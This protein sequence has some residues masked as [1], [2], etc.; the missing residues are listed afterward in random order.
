MSIDSDLRDPEVRETSAAPTTVEGIGR[1]P[2]PIHPP[3]WL[4]PVSIVLMVVVAAIIGVYVLRS[5]DE[6]TT[7]T[8]TASEP[9]IGPEEQ[10]FIDSRV[11]PLGRGT[12]TATPATAAPAVVV[13]ERPQGIAGM[14]EFYELEY[15][16]A[17]TPFALA[18]SP[19]SVGF[20]P[21]IGPEEQAFI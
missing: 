11:G 7:T 8:N 16:Q 9:W 3:R 21:L 13:H 17:K 14:I 1:T 5:D 6:P 19:A 20:P 10:A 12:A 4:A 18:P 15:I 2:R